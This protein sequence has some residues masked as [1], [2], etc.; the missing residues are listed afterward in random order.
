MMLDLMGTFDKSFDSE[1]AKRIRR[2]DTKRQNQGFAAGVN[3]RAAGRDAAALAA[4]QAGKERLAVLEASLAESLAKAVTVASDAETKKL[5]IAETIAPNEAD[6]KSTVSEFKSKGPE[7]LGTSSGFAA[8]LQS[9]SSGVALS[10]DQQM[11]TEA[12]V[13]S[14]LL[15]E[16]VKQMAKG[17]K[18]QA[19]PEF[20]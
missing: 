7:N 9:M 12:K 14:K 11:Y 5:A 3:D 4:E 1:G 15:G 18:L 2:E 17:S 10:L 16:I 19:E 8:M 13:Q 6:Y 20:T